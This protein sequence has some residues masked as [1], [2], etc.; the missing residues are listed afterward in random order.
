[1]SDAPD[2]TSGPWQ[3]ADVALSAWAA[4]TSREDAQLRAAGAPR[5]VED[6]AVVELR[7]VTDDNVRAICRLAVAPAQSRF[8]A[9]NAV[10]LA[11]AL[12]APLAWYR[13]VYADEQPVGFAML[14]IDTATPEY[15][16][17]RFMI[18]DDFQR[19][20]YGRVA[21]RLIL[22]HVRTLPGAAVLMTS[23]V[24]AEGG[25]EHFYRG[26]GFV[27]TGEV[28]D[29]EVVGRVDLRG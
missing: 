7:P 23:W 4:A 16:L 12:F 29:G 6:G 14:S 26:L 15:Y 10:S 19:R 17:W 25:P 24:P 2:A 28:D 27:P 22:D 9:P 11:Q 20:G 5:S 3:A 1:V 21:I 8:V 13:A 18:G